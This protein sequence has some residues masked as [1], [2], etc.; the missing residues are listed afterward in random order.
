MKGGTS[1]KG[2]GMQ[3]SLL[4]L[5]QHVFRSLAVHSWSDCRDFV[6]CRV[7]PLIASQ[8]CTIPLYHVLLWYYFLGQK[9][10][11]NESDE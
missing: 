1:H 7:L 6:M 5:S 3:L 8:T 2:V 11:A 10:K 9:D 4:S